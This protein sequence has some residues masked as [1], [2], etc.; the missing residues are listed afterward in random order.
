MTNSQSFFH[1]I[2]LFQLY[3]GKFYNKYV[4]ETYG[5]EDVRVVFVIHTEEGCLTK[6]GMKA[7]LIFLLH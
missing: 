1:S 5:K 6:L 2:K 4:E 7:S 3:C